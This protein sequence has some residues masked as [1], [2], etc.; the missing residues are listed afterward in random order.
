MS[1]LQSLLCCEL[2]A[3]Q[4]KMYKCK[5]IH[6]RYSML[7]EHRYFLLRQSVLGIY[8]EWEGFVKKS[9]A[10]YLQEINKEHVPFSE[11]HDYYISYQ[12][13]NIARFKS[14][15]TDL[16]TIA[17]L[18]R[19]L[20]EMYQGPVVFSTGVN[21][22]S[23]PNLKVTNSILSKLCLK[24]LSTKYESPLNKLLKFR[25]S[26]AHGDEGIPVTQS[27]VDS[28]TLLVQ[29]LATDFVLSVNEGFQSKVYLS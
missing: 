29:D 16:G 3:L 22:E 13:D 12:T 5:T 11:L 7:P 19:N 1:N 8:A 9:I 18:S 6:I 15:K 10:L 24:C 25:N 4:N 2:D 20:Y 14:P 28:F 17:K 26:I 27:D 21:T 23:N